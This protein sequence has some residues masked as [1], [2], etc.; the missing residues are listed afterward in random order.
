MFTYTVHTHRESTFANSICKANWLL[1]WNKD[2]LL[3][4]LCEHRIYWIKLIRGTVSNWKQISVC[5]CNTKLPS[6]WTNLV[7]QTLSSFLFAF[8]V[9]MDN[10]RY[11]YTRFVQLLQQILQ[12]DC[13]YVSGT[14]LLSKLPSKSDTLL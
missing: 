1:N 10:A 9:Q 12:L 8:V 7:F 6:M 11:F 3:V 4:Q 5:N 2:L 13:Y 14:N